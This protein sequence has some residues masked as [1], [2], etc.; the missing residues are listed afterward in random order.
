MNLFI[1]DGVF[2]SDIVEIILTKRTLERKKIYS[3]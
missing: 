2:K 1:R 3:M